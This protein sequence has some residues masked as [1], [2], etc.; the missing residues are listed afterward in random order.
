[1]A[2]LT[3]KSVFKLVM[4]LIHRYVNNVETVVF[5]L[6]ANFLWINAMIVLKHVEEVNFVKPIMKTT[7][8]KDV[9]I[10]INTVMNVEMSVQETVAVP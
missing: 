8:K 5:Q 7:I 2:A 10:A 1:M 4:R 9:T 3:A 6:N